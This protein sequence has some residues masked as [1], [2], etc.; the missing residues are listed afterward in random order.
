[1]QLS[2]RCGQVIP[3]SQGVRRDKG[4]SM[5]AGDDVS[6]GALS[7]LTSSGFCTRAIIHEMKFH[8]A[9]KNSCVTVGGKDLRRGLP[10]SLRGPTALASETTGD[11]TT[12]QATKETGAIYEARP[13]VLKAAPLQPPNISRAPRGDT[14]SLDSRGR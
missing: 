6:E 3:G 4:E 9:K 10:C 13:V 5:Q 1:M 7:S 11:L 2:S 12:A 8:K 14:A